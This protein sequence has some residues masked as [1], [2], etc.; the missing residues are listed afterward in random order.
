MN[1]LSAFEKCDSSSSD[2]KVIAMGLVVF[3]LFVLGCFLYVLPIWIA[4]K[5]NHPRAVAI[6]KWNF[7]AGWTV[8]GWAVALVW[9]CL[10]IVTPS[11][12]V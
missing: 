12:D 8:V 7:L 9:S 11:H 4:G 2:S 1:S 3:I 6:F 5:R 10:P